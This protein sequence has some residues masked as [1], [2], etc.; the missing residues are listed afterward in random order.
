M[1]HWIDLIFGFK[2][3]GPEAVKATNVFCHLTYEGSVNWAKV[4]YPSNLLGMCGFVCVLRLT[5]HHVKLV[6]NFTNS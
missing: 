1:H 2:Q 4:S 5:M 6:L 3:L